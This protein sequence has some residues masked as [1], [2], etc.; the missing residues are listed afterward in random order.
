MTQSIAL[1]HITD[2]NYEI[3]LVDNGST[4]GSV[5]YFRK[6]YQGMTIIENGAYLGF[7]ERKNVGIRDA[8]EEGK[9]V[10]CKLK[11]S[12]WGGLEVT[13]ANNNYINQSRIE[14]WMLD[15]EFSDANSVESLFGASNILKNTKGNDSN[16]E[17]SYEYR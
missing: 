3:L 17:N 14:D 1:K 10:I 11:S 9:N 13:N 7:A 6:R 5:E 8:M 4:D 15:E 16:L 12:W 2:P